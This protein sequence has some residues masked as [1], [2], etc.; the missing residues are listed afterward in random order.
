M[1]NHII[2]QKSIEIQAIQPI[3]PIIAQELGID[4]INERMTITETPDFIFF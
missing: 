1:G 4:Y 2:K 3:L